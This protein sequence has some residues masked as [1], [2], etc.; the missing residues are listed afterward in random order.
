MRIVLPGQHI[1]PSEL[2]RVGPGVQ[3]ITSISI[4]KGTATFSFSAQTPS[5]FSSSL[6]RK[7]HLLR[8]FQ[9]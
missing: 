6:M 4:K 3:Q 9:V 7:D 2:G 1:T 8:E 5:L